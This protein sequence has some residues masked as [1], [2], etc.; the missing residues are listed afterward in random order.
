MI[1]FKQL[2]FFGQRFGNFK[3]FFFSQKIKIFN[4][5][6]CF[7][8]RI[9]DHISFIIDYGV[10]FLGRQDR[11]DT[12]FYSAMSGNT[13]CVRLEPQVK[14]VPFFHGVPFFQ[15]LQHRNGRIQSLYIGF[16]CIF[17]NDIHNLLPDQK[18]FRKTI[19]RVRVCRFGNLWS[20]AL[21]LH[22]SNARGF[23]RVKQ[24]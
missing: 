21:A 16:F 9:D 2:I 8:T 13:R 17:R 6:N 18:S 10:E 1:V 23:P 19:H 7:N 14:C 22:R 5:V 24:D 15:L 12:R 3:I 11:A 20:L 4:T